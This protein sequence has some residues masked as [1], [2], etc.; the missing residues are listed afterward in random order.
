MLIQNGVDGAAHGLAIVDGDSLLGIEAVNGDAKHEVRA[1]LDVFHVPEVVAQLVGGGL[2]DLPHLVRNA[3]TGG[4]GTDGAI[5]LL[6]LVRHSV[7]LLRRGPRKKSP[8]KI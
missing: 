4:T 1:L 2:D 6:D 8:S 3:A 5:G 7:S